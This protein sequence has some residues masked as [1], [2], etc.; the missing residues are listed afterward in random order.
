MIN[1]LISDLAKKS[2]LS[3][4]TIRFYEKKGLIKPEFRANNQYRYFNESSL[5][6]LLLIKRYRS[7]NIGL[8]EIENLI[9]LEHTP[10]ADCS[11]LNTILDQHINEIENKI[12]ELKLFQ[13]ELKQLRQHCHQPTTVQDCQIFKTLENDNQS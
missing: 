13:K 8:K 4:D 11:V 5:K 6:R 2:G 1:Y 3:S 7:L 10:Q 12:N 9:G